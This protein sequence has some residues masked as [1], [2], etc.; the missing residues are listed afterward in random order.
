MVSYQSSGQDL[1]CTAAAGVHRPPYLGAALYVQP[2]G[3]L[4]YWQT[5]SSTKAFTRRV[6]PPSRSVEHHLGLP[7]WF[8]NVKMCLYMAPSRLLPQG[9]LP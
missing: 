9:G 8:K 1:V 3:Q 5:S 7:Q 6:V 4:V 2:Y